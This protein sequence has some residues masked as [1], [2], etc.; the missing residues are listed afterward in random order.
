MNRLDEAASENLAAWGIPD[1]DSKAGL[2]LVDLSSYYN[3]GVDQAW[4]TTNKM[5]NDLA[6]LP[7]GLQTLAGAKFD[8]R[9]II[10]LTST[11]L[12]LVNPIYPSEVTDVRVGLR[13]RQLHF[14]HAT[15]WYAPDGVQIGTYTLHYAD[16]QQREIP[17]LYGEHVRNWWSGRDKKPMGAA[18]TVAWSGTNT[19]QQPL[20][21]FKTTW[22]N[23]RPETE[24]KSL[25]FV[26]TGTQCAPFL[27]AVTVE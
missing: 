22:V 14:L 4:C 5:G 17:I 10:Q 1:R 23:P 16:G 8:I 20:R 7:H 2:Q 19:F 24:I 11:E 3:A 27:I 9:G 26:S 18:T 15:G 21:I 6:N 25:D 12:D 13:A